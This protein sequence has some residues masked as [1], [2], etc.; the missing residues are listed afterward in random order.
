MVQPSTE[1]DAAWQTHDD[2]LSRSPP[3]SGPQRLALTS[4]LIKEGLAICNS[5]AHHNPESGHSR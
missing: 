5:D 3:P 4:R 1:K 2:I